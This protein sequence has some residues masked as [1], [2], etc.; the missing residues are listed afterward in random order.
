MNKSAPTLPQVSQTIAELMPNI[1]RGAQLDLFAGGPITQTQFMLLVAI[2]ASGPVAMNELASSMKIKMPT[3]TG[4]INRLSASGYVRRSSDAKDRRK[5]RVEITP[6]GMRF[7]EKFRRV[8]RRRWEEV[9]TVLEPAE[10]KTFHRLV[11]KL[12]D[13]TSASKVKHAR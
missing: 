1:I 8:M 4:L 9:L 10:L 2:Q 3:A 7:F 11:S 5:V 13:S 12:R 6:A